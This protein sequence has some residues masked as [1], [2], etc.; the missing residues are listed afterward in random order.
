YL[1][2]ENVVTTDVGG[3]SF[4]VSIVAEG[5]PII[6]REPPILRYRISIP[7]IE[8]NSIGAGGGTIAWIDPAGSFKVGPVSAG[9][10]PGPVCYC[11][12][13]T[14]PTVTDADLVLG[15]FN[16]DYFLGGRLKLDKDAANSAI[17]KLGEKMGWGV[18]ETARAIFTIQNEHMTDLLRLMVTR[19]GY[20]PRDFA[21]FAFGGGGPTHA[22]FYA[23]PLSIKSI[24]MFPE[25]SVFSA[26]GIATS[27][28]Q[29]IFNISIYA[30]L[31]GDNKEIA[32]RLNATYQDL[33]KKAITE[34][35]K[36]GFRK[37]EV[38]LGRGISMK[39]GRQVNM[40]TI[41]IPV[42]DYVATDID[43]IQK[44]F[45]EHYTRIYGEG[46]AFVEAGM[47]IM[48]EAVTATI[49]S[50]AAPPAKR[51]LGSADASKALKGKRDVYWEKLGDFHST[52]I[53]DFESVMPGNTI[54]GPAIIE[55]TTTTFVIPP[56][57]TAMMNE[58]GHIV[59]ELR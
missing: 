18:I 16:P 47:E 12:G 36:A 39:F 30:R 4:D 59:I 17:K 5:K 20:D 14:E 48:S 38:V 55:A 43:D 8:V 27:D 32:K 37:E 11:K 34:M 33:D 6:A 24:Y 2:L 7:T 15:Y 56:D 40:E 41:D 46:A 9:A 23:T 21:V 35:E 28:I 29:R 1:G 22:P 58:Y 49:K 3:T 10:L 26:Y 50:S 53:Y 25:S 54:K 42:K 13:G 44:S 45:V 31:P 51:P 19:R 52:D 57:L